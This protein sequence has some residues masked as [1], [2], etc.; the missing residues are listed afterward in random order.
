MVEV[1]GDGGPR[2]AT[3]EEARLAAR[4][5]PSWMGT[6]NAK[7]TRVKAG[8]ASATALVTVIVYVA[9]VLPSWAVTF[10]SIVLLPELSDRDPEGEP[11]VTEAYDPLLTRT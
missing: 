11:E 4:R 6:A 2:A 9:V 7:E 3:L 1:A 10:T 8:A 5:D